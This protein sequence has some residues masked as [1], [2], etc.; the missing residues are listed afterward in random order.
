[1]KRHS[2]S[3][4]GPLLSGGLLYLLNGAFVVFVMAV[5]PRLI[6]LSEESPRLAALGWLALLKSPVTFVAV[7]HRAAHGVL[8]R[9]DPTKRECGAVGSLWAGLF[10]W[11][12]MLF[13]SLVAAFLTVA[14]F[15]PPVDE[16]AVTAFVRVLEDGR[17]TAS[18]HTILWVAAA[19]IL[20]AVER[21]SRQSDA[22]AP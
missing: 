2:A 17:I 19:S 12:G 20:Y 7:V 21:A 14:I 8:D 6:D 16:D 15:P 1:M 11:F 5:L 18:V 13:S 10:A 22:A 4:L 3:P 9:L